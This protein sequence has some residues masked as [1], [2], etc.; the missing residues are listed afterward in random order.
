[1]RNIDLDGLVIDNTAEGLFRVNRRVFTDPDILE[2]ERQRVFE[3][4]WIYAGHESEIPQ[5]GDFRA[6]NVAG[7]PV[8][9]VRGSDGQVRVLLN[10]CTH[11]GAL[12]CRQPSGNTKSFQCPYHAWTFSNQGELIGVPGEEAYSAA[13][14]RR[15][16]ALAMAP[17][18]ES[19]RG[20]VTNVVRYYEYIREHD[21]TLTHALINLQRSRPAAELFQLSEETALHVVRETNAGLVLRGARVLATLGPLAE[22]IAIYSPRMRRMKP[23]E[24][25][26][27]ALAFAIPCGTL[28]LKFLCRESFD[29]G[30]SHF[31]HPLGSRF[32]E[33]DCI[34]FFDEVLV[35]WERVFLLGDVERLNEMMTATHMTI[36]TG[37]QG[38]AK[39]VAKCEF[40]LGVALLM[41]HTL[42]STQQPHVQERLR[43]REAYREGR[44]DP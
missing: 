20:F 31:D 3:H 36:H 41:A 5:P 8:V 35:P 28:G 43:A 24:E 2:L 11:R 32:E 15:E 33:M 29:L 27:Y 22:E 34:V 9:L 44:R 40:L 16:L 17:R 12:V 19:Y 25:R 21:L 13:F 1:M 37:H 10:T 18:L 14:D 30:R 42:R 26:R 23:E 7:R 6:R 38:G 4:S 39:N